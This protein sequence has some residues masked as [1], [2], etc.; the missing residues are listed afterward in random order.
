MKTGRLEA[1]SDGVLAIVITIMVLEFE[2]PESGEWGAL[3]PLYPVFLTYLLSFVFLGIYW[4][5]HHH[6][7]H[8]AERVSGAVLWA[9]LLLL[10]WLSLIPFTTRWMGARFE[11]VP[12]AVYGGVLFLSAVSWGILE[13]AILRLERDGSKLKAAVGDRKKEMVSTGLYALALPLAFV[14]PWIAVGIYVSVALL[15]LVPD[16][17]I[18]RRT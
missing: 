18:E 8:A 14:Q 9:N 10:F 4:S 12:V 7:M 11:P 1:F 2:V 13:K 17:R 5:N 3:R 6:L 16:P 15:W